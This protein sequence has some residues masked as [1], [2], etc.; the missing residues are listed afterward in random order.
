MKKIIFV[1]LASVIAGG[2]LFAQALQLDTESAFYLYLK[3]SKT[4]L[5]EDEKLDYA[6]IVESDTYNKYKNDE[7]EWDEKFSAIKNKLADKINS[8]DLNAVYTIVTSVEI[9][10]YNFEKEGFPV[11]INEG[12]YF[13]FERFSGLWSYGISEKSIL[14][15]QS[16]FKLDGFEKY[17]FIAMPK[18]EAK[19]FLQGRKNSWGDVNR[20]VTLQITYKIAPFDSKEYKNFANLAKQNDYL[21]IVGSIENIEVYDVTNRKNVKKI[22]NLVCN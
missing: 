22:G 20:N 5:S 8:T 2:S 12:V 16:A 7:F 17:N 10:D 4:E 14:Y 9:G 19:K 3:G 18:A 21:P 15:K 11:A 6:K 1:L 13:P